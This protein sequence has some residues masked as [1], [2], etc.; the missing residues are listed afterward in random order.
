MGA[1]LTTG[2]PTYA[3]GLYGAA[4]KKN[5]GLSKG[6]LDT[7][8]TAFFVA[9]LLSWAPGLFAD[10]YGARLAICIGGCTG[11]ASLLLYWCIAKEYVIIHSHAVLVTLLSLLGIFTFESSAMV[12]GSVFKVLTVTAG[13]RKGTAVGV[14]KGLVGLGSG[15]Y[16]CMF[17]SIKTSS[18][19]DLD[20]LPL[21]AVLF[22]ACATVP[23]FFLIPSRKELQSSEN[24]TH[25]AVDWHFTAL[26]AGL[27]GMGVLII[28]DSLAELFR[29][30]KEEDDDTT[31]DVRGS[32]KSSWTALAL[33]VLWWG[34]LVAMYCSH[35]TPS[36]NEHGLDD[37]HGESSAYQTI[38]SH[39]EE[40]EDDDDQDNQQESAA[41]RIDDDDE[42][43]AES[44]PADEPE[45]T[46]LPNNDNGAITTTALASPI[47]MAHTTAIHPDRNLFQMLQTPEAYCLL[48]SAT[49]MVGSGVSI[50]KLVP[51]P[52]NIMTDWL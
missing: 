41:F 40:E 45:T 51:L 7:I 5:L 19:S 29:D 31:N 20:F 12:T 16:T 38:Q 46:L 9:G 32:G 6:D 44:T 43:T 13:P 42:N 2:G 22:L 47:I 34:P 1:A 4:L 30:E 49:I 8:S 27:M 39:E 15:V 21:A 24:F 52:K 25:D 17:E 11:C 50:S 10:R 48:W 35:K 28:W 14:A 37:D 3:F 26:Y 33:F 18:E 23:A 36:T